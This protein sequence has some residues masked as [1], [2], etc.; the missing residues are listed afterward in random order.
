MLGE[1]DGLMSISLSAKGDD[2]VLLVPGISGGFPES[3][4]DKKRSFVSMDGKEVFKFAVNAMCGE[5]RN[6]ISMAGISEEEVDWV[7]PHQANM[8]IID[9]AMDKLNIPAE[10]YC[11]NIDHVGN[12][13]AA[14]IP[15]LLDEMNS[16]GRFKRGDIL[17][18]CVFG[19]GLTSG[20][21]V[22]RW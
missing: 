16:L 19:A 15:I 18:I 21:A 12:T 4:D 13:S 7:V 2:K 17:A 9:F 10:K 1:G 6:T 11:V 20:S 3:Q 22:I 5:L 14:C 8:R